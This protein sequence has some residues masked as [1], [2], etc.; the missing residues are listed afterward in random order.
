M[1]QLPLPKD[2]A[3]DARDLWSAA[4]RQ[5]RAQGTWE[6]TDRPLLEM[7]VRNLVA[8]R[9]APEA[10]DKLRHSNPTEQQVAV[11]QAERAEAAVFALA[12]VLLLTPEARRHHGVAPAKRAKR[13]CAS[14]DRSR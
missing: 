2:F 7:Y 5:L 8:A 4:Q 11:K 3:E 1:R 12:K 9:H 14:R 13:R 6:R 10:A